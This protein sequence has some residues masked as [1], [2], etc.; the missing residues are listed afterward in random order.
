MGGSIHEQHAKEHDVTRN[1]T[2]LRV[3]NLQSDN[4]TNLPLLDVVE[5]DVVG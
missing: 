4:G 1:T 5:V 2:R 3:V